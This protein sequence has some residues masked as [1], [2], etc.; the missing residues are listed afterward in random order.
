MTPP[1]DNTLVIALAVTFSLL[2]AA[3]I[4]VVVIVLYLKVGNFKG[5]RYTRMGGISIKNNFATPIHRVLV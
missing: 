3:I 1:E 2:G 5:Y 4:I